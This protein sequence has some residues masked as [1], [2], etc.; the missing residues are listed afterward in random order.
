MNELC[1][2]LAKEMPLFVHKVSCPYPFKNFMVI[3]L[4][5]SCILHS[6]SVELLHEHISDFS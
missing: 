2:F 1:K 6:L 3:L 5:H 4:S